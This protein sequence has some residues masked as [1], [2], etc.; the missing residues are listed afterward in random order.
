M[1][2]QFVMSTVSKTCL[3][4]ETPSFTTWLNSNLLK[5]TLLL[6]VL[7][8]Q[9][10]QTLLSVKLLP[11]SYSVRQNYGLILHCAFFKEYYL[12][13]YSITIDD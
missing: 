6:L 10:N 8:T 7:K 4:L 13:A 9:S 2:T 5:T 1:Y 3:V 12:K 11:K